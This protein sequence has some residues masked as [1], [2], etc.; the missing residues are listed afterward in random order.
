M[1]AEGDE[2][3]AKGQEAKDACGVQGPSPTRQA[4]GTGEGALKTA[5]PRPRPAPPKQIQVLEPAMRGHREGRAHEVVLASITC[6]LAL[7]PEFSALPT[8]VLHPRGPWRTQCRADH[9]PRRSI[10]SLI[11]LAAFSLRS[12]GWL[13]LMENSVMTPEQRVSSGISR[14]GVEGAGRE[15][16]QHWTPTIYCAHPELKP[17]E[18]ESERAAVSKCAVG[19]SNWG[20]AQ[21]TVKDRDQLKAVLMESTAVLPERDT[22]CDTLKS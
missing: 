19:Y 12:P 9:L 20:R 21:T 11:L 16:P 5:W 18:P 2:H 15:A 14:R 1:A 13:L 4:S 8:A 7:T 10:V 22:L 17:G 3:K 6:T